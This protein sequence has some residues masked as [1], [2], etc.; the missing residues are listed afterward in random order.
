MCMRHIQNNNFSHEPAII[1][2]MKKHRILILVILGII[3]LT[4]IL[5]RTKRMPFSQPKVQKQTVAA[6]TPGVLPFPGGN[7]C[8]TSNATGAT[9]R[10]VFPVK[11]LVANG[12][13]DNYTV[14]QNAINT[15]EIKGGGIIKL[16]AG[17]F[18]INGHIEMKNN[19]TL[20]G[21]GPSTII[22]AGPNFL[23]NPSSVGYSV[24]SAK[25]VSN[26]TIKNLTADQQGNK[27]DGNSI[28]RFLGYVIH[29]YQSKNV[30]VNGVYVRNPF[31][32]SIVAEESTNFC[33][34]QNNTRVV[35]SGKYDQL[36]G[37]HVLNSS[38]GDVLNN[39]I[40]QGHGADG[41]D[42]LAA[43]TINGSTH[44]ITYAGNKIR[45]G[46]GGSC[47][48][49]ALTNTTDTIYNIKIQNN[50]CW[51][52]PRGIRTGYYGENGETGGSVYN[53][54]IG[55]SAKTGNYI[56]DNIFNNTN[57]GDAINIYGNGIDPFNIT[58]S[59][60]RTCKA[61]TIS[62]GKGNNNNAKYNIG[63]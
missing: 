35:T 53:I 5:V 46:K 3:I 25:N 39:Y 57:V 58:V 36:D 30:N 44:D 18:L 27:L 52:S 62:V 15:A 23:K 48:Q 4:L 11:H 21:A 33:F 14:I 7:A 32:Y 55:G 38:F 47:M 28:N 61:G 56:H 6:P 43:H 13:T 2:Y 40:D 51:G 17:T 34:K 10:Q 1:Y 37:I 16:P 60:N 41:D 12:K 42:G 49:L 31:T 20:E 54:I 63:C 24:I 26:V 19:V 45:G 29:V 22:K 8:S 9:A 50:E 59:Y